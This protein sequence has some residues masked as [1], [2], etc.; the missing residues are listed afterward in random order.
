MPGLI[1]ALVVFAVIVSQ[2]Y[3]GP[4]KV[5]RQRS[6][7]ILRDAVTWRYVGLFL[8]LCGCA[9]YIWGRREV[10]MGSIPTDRV[11][12]IA[13][14]SESDLT[15]PLDEVLLDGYFQP[16]QMVKVRFPRSVGIMNQETL[17]IPVTQAD[18]QAGEPVRLYIIPS[19]FR[20]GT[21]GQDL[22]DAYVKEGFPPQGSGAVRQ[23]RLLAKAKLHSFDGDV[24][25]TVAQA[26]LPTDG[27]VQI[28]GINEN[29]REYKLER[30]FEGA[31]IL[32]ILLAVFGGLLVWGSY[33][34]RR[35]AQRQQG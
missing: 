33:I 16:D 29:R 11:V 7:G 18:W 17:L 15:G 25:E 27:P 23:T 28:L 24:T 31:K 8:L 22:V 35:Y 26:G 6:A 1:A 13:D 10:A 32:A 14:F 12:S 4:P 30:A 2:I 21:V 19:W 9:A 3:K 20:T 5:R 34:A